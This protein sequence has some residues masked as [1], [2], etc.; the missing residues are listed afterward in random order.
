MRDAFAN[1]SK[2]EITMLGYDDFTQEFIERLKGQIPNASFIRQEYQKIN[3]TR[4]GLSIKF[5]G[6][7]LA[8]TIYLRDAYQQYVDGMDMDVLVK[9]VS[10]HLHEAKLAM[11]D[12]PRLT[13]EE[14]QKNLYAMV[15]N[16]ERNKDL[17]Q[18]A[19]YRMIGESDL[20]IVA[21]FKVHED[22]KGS[23]S[24]L[25]TKEMCAYMDLTQNQTLDIAIANS[26]D[27][28]YTCQNLSQVMGEL[29]LRN[30]APKED[31]EE[32]MYAFKSPLYRVTNHSC[33]QGAIAIGLPSVLKD[34]ARVLGEPHAYVLPSSVDEILMVPRSIGDAIGVDR[35]SS[36]VKEVNEAQVSVD[37][38][39]SDN[40]Y[41]WNGKTLS[42]AKGMEQSYGITK[43]FE[44]IFG[45][46]MEM[47]GVGGMDEA[48]PQTRTHK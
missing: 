17:L 48:K 30:G 9:G 16:Y 12:L 36:I 24:F 11:P 39:L 29:M 46:G 2:G 38:Q 33:F 47:P 5:D 21:R 14:A 44:S 13:K 26:D 7:S 18:N 6:D 37:N 22:H 31:V 28:V 34:S 3:Q 4:D 41:L 42:I 27:Q 35:L 23:S 20:C 15:V 1:N 45:K 8:P 40:I 32:M 10:T 19:P 43:G 25:M